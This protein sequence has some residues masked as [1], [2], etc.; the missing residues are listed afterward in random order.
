MIGTRNSARNDGQG[1]QRIHRNNGWRGEEIACK[2]CR[3]AC[4]LH[5]DLDGKGPALGCVEAEKL[6]HKVAEQ[7]TGAVVECHDGKRESYQTQSVRFQLWVNGEDDASHNTGQTQD[8]YAG[9]DALNRLEILPLAQE[10]VES[11]AKRHWQKRHE[12]NVLEH[13]P[14]INLDFRS[15]KPQYEKRRHERRKHSTHGCHA[16]TICH[17]AFA[18]KAHN[19]TTHASRTASDQ[20]NACRHKGV[21]L[22]SPSQSPRHQRHDGVLCNGSN[23]DVCR[24]GKQDAEVF[25]RKRAAHRQH[26]E[27]ENNRRSLPFLHPRKGAWKDET[28]DGNQDDEEACV[29]S[30]PTTQGQECGHS[31]C[32][33]FN[34][35]AKVQRKN[36]KTSFRTH[37]LV[38]NV[39]WRNSE[40]ID[41]LKEKC[42]QNAVCNLVQ[43]NVKN[44]SKWQ[45]LSQSTAKIQMQRA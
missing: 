32:A 12:Q 38:F 43:N 25:R 6:A 17:I 39:S 10:I 20:Y 1:C 33:S 22:E 31:L 27:A 45:V 16:D 30:Q 3:H 2:D 9:H 21:E 5:S 40:V 24:S 26:D 23:Q 7:V 42:L 14:G 28:D 44:F 4:I 13:T 19:V 18:K 36:R 41:K 29:S 35:A 15:C 8:T 37:F 34:L 11:H